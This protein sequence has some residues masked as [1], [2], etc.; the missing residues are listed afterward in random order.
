VVI[1]CVCALG[2]VSAAGA[3]PTTKA[4]SVK[5]E[6]HVASL[7]HHQQV[8]RFFDRN[9]WLLTDSR[10]G[11]EARRQLAL[12]TERER[13]TRR[14]MGR[15]R[16]DLKSARVQE[17]RRQQVRRLAALKSAP[18]R[19]AICEVFGRQ[20]CDDALAVAHCESRLRVAAQNGQY[21][22]LFQMGSSERRRYGHGASAYEQ[23][24]AAHAYF[25]A[26][27]RDWSPWT[28]KPWW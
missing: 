16:T 12:H 24:K 13:V 23:A 25:V 3:Q 19:R 21:L 5:L 11:A 26:S 9:G 2:A 10:F 8:I 18:P 22:G 14:K 4:L 1:V 28:C 17:R 15:V 20:H 27:G 7:R 6:R